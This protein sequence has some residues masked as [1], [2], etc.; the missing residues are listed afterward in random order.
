MEYPS[1]IA[2]LRATAESGPGPGMLH[3]SLPRLARVW[4]M[5]VGGLC[6]V[7]GVVR[8]LMVIRLLQC[9]RRVP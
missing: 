1:D 7:V 6:Q 4:A 3:A 8:G 5:R 9:A 2:A